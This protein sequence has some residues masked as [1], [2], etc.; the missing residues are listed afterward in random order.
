MV[1][2]EKFSEHS[3]MLTSKFTN[4]VTNKLKKEAWLHITG[5]VNALGVEKRIVSEM[6]KNWKNT[7]SE[8]KLTYNVRKR[9]VKKTGGGPPPPEISQELH[10][11]I[12]M[13]SDQDGF[14][15]I[16][17]GIDSFDYDFND[18]IELQS[19]ISKLDS[20]SVIAVTTAAST[21]IPSTSSEPRTAS[22]NTSSFSCK[23]KYDEQASRK[24]ILEL[25]EKSKKYDTQLLC[26][27]MKMQM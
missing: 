8:A 23:R 12:E 18:N 6:K 16:N 17:G 15:G 7:E 4:S 25:E 19:L 13:H 2:R 11:I 5:A 14:A 9:E 21:D 20:N 1:L 26:K 22:V 3:E 24:N 27:S 10:E